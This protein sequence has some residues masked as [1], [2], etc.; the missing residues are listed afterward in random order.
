MKHIYTLL[1]CLLTTGA[2]SAQAEIVATVMDSSGITLPGANAVLLRAQDSLL[3]SFGTT[4]NDGVFRM[5]NVPAGKYLLRITFLGYERP[6]QSLDITTDDQY[7]GLGELKMYPAGFFLNGVEVTADRIPIRMKGDT[8]MYDAGAFAVGENAVVEDL[9]RRL[10]GMSVDASGQITWR[11]KPITEVMINGKPFFAG[12]STLLTQNLDAKAIKNV[13]VYDQK[14]DSEEVSGIDDGNE[15]MTVNLEMKDDFKAKVFGELFAGGGTNERYQAG[16]KLFRISDVSQI[17]VLGTIN[18]INKVGFSGDEISG[19]NGSSGRGRGFG[20]SGDQNGSLPFDNGNATGQNRSIATGVNFGR[21]VGK[22][23]QLTADY[24]L[25]NRNQL[26]NSTTLQA[27]NRAQDNRIVET[28]EG[29]AVGQYSHRL[30]F[31]FRQ[32]IDSTSRLTV[33]GAGFISGGDNETEANTFIRNGATEIDDYR[34]NE[35]STSERPGGE[36]SLSYNRGRG[37]SG[38]GFMGGGGPAGRTFEANLDASYRENQSD[39]DLLTEGLGENPNQVIGA[40]INGLQNQNRVTTTTNLGGEVALTEPLSDKWRLRGEA[41]YDYDSDAGDYRFRFQENTTVNLLTRDWSSLNGQLSLIRTIG[42]GGNVSF[43]TNY[44]SAKLQ[45]SG[46]EARDDTYNFLL[47]FVRYRNRLKKGFLSINFNSSANAPA[48]SQLQTIAEPNASGRV[49]IGNPSLT[50][51][52]NHRFSSYLWYNDQ[53]RA[54]SANANVSAAYT[55]N[56]FGNSVTFSDGQQIFQTINVGHAW[57]G[58]LFL[59]TTIGINAIQGE[60]RIEG[61]LNGSRGIGFVDGD[62]QLNTSISS[63]VGTNITAELNEDSYIKLGYTLTNFTNSFKGED[64]EATNINQLTH[65]LLA[66]FELEVSPKWRF[67]SRFLY[68][69]F[70]ASDFAAAQNIPDLRLSLELRPFRKKAH[71]FRI[72]ASDIFNQNTIVNRNVGNFVTTES[73]SDGLGRYFLGTFHFKI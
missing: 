15:N 8:M 19:F 58:N 33:E 44:Q 54:I 13:E 45:L 72:S 34:V 29:N 11:G 69:I 31:E 47:P 14:S 51:A 27:F 12:N 56:A 71:F 46:D 43:G 53:F 42:K 64:T 40:L 55:D 26:Q 3:T 22:N 38:R 36:I 61:G 63:N 4:D 50:P 48:I 32:R 10:P 17:G 18:N 25:F 9:I 6:D 24:A 2:I 65:D 52:T 23:G 41:G 30:G 70:A 28:I 62:S 20:F 39:L 1:F 37:G 57:S 68:S 59:G 49:S 5:Q 67:E 60:I 16:G 73:T 21:T 35:M 66:Q 7:F